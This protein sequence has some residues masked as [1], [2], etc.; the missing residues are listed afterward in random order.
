M[1]E[2][3]ASLLLIIGKKGLTKRPKYRNLFPMME[4]ATTGELPLRMATGSIRR[5][6]L[7]D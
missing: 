7:S 1:I 3:G 2:P 5:K 6:R 4:V